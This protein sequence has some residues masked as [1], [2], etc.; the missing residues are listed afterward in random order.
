MT[1]IDEAGAALCAK[2]F[3]AEALP[4]K[5]DLSQ[6]DFHGKFDLI[7]SGSLVTHLIEKDTRAFFDLIA[8]HLTDDGIAVIST[9]GDLVGERLKTATGWMYG[10]SDADQEDVY[11]QAQKGGYGYCRYPNWETEYGISLSTREWLADAARSAGLAMTKHLP[12]A[13]DNHQDVIGLTL[14]TD[15]NL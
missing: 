9:H 1:D 12:S 3:G 7:W 10:L 2:M 13:W 11:R 14:K 8:R 5:L 15:R 4:S 6:V